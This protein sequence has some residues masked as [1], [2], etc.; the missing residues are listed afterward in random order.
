MRLSGAEPISQV[1]YNGCLPVTCASRSVHGLEKCTQNS[2][3]SGIAFTIYTNQVN[4]PKNGRGGRP[5]TGIKRWLWRNGTRIPVWEI[6]SGKKQDYLFRFSVAPGNVPLER[7]KTFCS[8]SNRIFWKLFENGNQP[9]TALIKNMESYFLSPK[10]SSNLPTQSLIDWLP[11]C[12]VLVP[13]GHAL[14]LVICSV[15]W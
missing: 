9:I 1:N 14:Q 3:R 4:L 11:F 6:P 15:S 5:E 10:V 13:A 8:I 12:K 2:E 7:T